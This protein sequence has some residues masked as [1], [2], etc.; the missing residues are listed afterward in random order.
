MAR[1]GY[2]KSVPFLPLQP[3][4]EGFAGG[5]AQFDPVGFSEY[6]PMDWLREAELKHGRVCMLATLGFVA[7]D[8]GLRIPGPEHAYSSIQVSRVSFATSCAA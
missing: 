8:L 7:T 6:I 4:L 3:K 1:D 5:D 2:S